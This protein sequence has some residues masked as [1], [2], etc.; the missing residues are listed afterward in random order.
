MDVL[1]VNGPNL[2]ALGSREPEIY[3]STTLADIEAA[4][5]AQGAAAGLDVGVFQS[6]HEGALIDR[7][8]QAREE[9]VRYI[10]INPGGLTH[11]S[12]ALRDALAGVAIPFVELHI[13]NVH[14]REDFRRRS[15]LSDLAVGVM[16]GFGAHGYTMAMDFVCRQLGAVTPPARR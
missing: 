11:T 9:G 15:L 16:A 5:T 13:S 3:G 14:A 2:N 7:L 10:V 4:L 1:V 8:Y 6:N 12:V